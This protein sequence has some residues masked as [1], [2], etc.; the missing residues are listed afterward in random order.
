MELVDSDDG[1]R[2]AASLESCYGDVALPH[3]NLAVICRRECNVRS[4]GR[5]LQYM[6]KAVP[7]RPKMM[8]A[9][10]G[11]MTFHTSA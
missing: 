8:A 7:R 5:V 11:P 4:C 2:A 10:M 6:T 9:K 3:W 1:I